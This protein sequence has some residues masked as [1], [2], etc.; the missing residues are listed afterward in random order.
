[1]ALQAVGVHIEQ[2]LEV[3]IGEKATERA[4]TGDEA[5]FD[6]PTISSAAS[7]LPM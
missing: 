1:M 3:A 6:F 5:G 4:V 7:R 2:T